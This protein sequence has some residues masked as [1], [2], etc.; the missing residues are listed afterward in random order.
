MNNHILQ[1]RGELAIDKHIDLRSRPGLK[2]SVLFIYVPYL[3]S[4]STFVH[5]IF[6]SFG[7]FFFSERMLHLINIHDNMFYV[8]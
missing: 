1:G 8:E 7:V 2:R 4:T 6:W 3:V 5:L